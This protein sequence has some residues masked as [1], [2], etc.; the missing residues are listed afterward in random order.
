MNHRVKGAE[1]L[2]SVG[3]LDGEVFVRMVRLGIGG[4][5]MMC[6]FVAVPVVLAGARRRL[7]LRAQSRSEDEDEGEV[8]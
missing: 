5:G 3:G 1:I 4:H 7:V 6:G 2:V 8:E